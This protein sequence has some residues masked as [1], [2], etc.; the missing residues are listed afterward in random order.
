[1]YYGRVVVEGDLLA[2]LE[3]GNTQQAKDIIHKFPA[4][5][6]D[7][8]SSILP[9]MA[10]YGHDKLL[11][12]VIAS[13]NISAKEKITT[14]LRNN[15]FI[16]LVLTQLH[17]ASIDSIG[18]ILSKASKIGYDKLVSELLNEFPNIRLHMKFVSFK[19]AFFNGHKNTALILLN[20]LVTNIQDYWINEQLET[21]ELAAHMGNSNLVRQLLSEISTEENTKAERALL[22]AAKGGHIELLK[23][24]LARFP[25]TG[26][27]A[28]V[29]VEA[30][31]ANQFRL[32]EELLVM[33]SSHS[34]SNESDNSAI[35]FK[36]TEVSAAQMSQLLCRRG[37]NSRLIQLLLNRF[38]IMEGDNE[39]IKGVI[40][41]S[42]MN[43]LDKLLWEWIERLPTLKQEQ[44][45]QENQ[46][47]FYVAGLG[48]H[49][50]IIVALQE[51][52]PKTGSC[53]IFEGAVHGGHKDL[54]LSFFK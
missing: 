49:E 29:L 4:T 23:E 48:G 28:K 32:V 10:I 44:D 35:L 12:E 13:S 16:G 31:I 11:E 50:N 5:L 47:I 25:N 39:V 46:D 34:E 54:A 53:H 51:K 21:L 1:M 26:S 6:L 8:R 42:A 2:L 9:Y 19:E 24:L 22:G 7:V 38:P 40:A 45:T 41:N 52:F 17:T 20:D 43:G 14:Q 15:D 30:A 37:N 18:T 33:P 27:E 3:K 36:C